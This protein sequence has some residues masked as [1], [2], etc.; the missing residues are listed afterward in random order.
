[1][2]WTAKPLIL[3]SLSPSQALSHYPFPHLF[4]AVS[5]TSHSA[6]Y[7]IC[8]AALLMLI[9]CRVNRHVNKPPRRRR[10]EEES[11]EVTKWS[12]NREGVDDSLG[13]LCLATPTPGSLKHRD[14]QLFH[15]RVNPVN[16]SCFLSNNKC[17]TIIIFPR[18]CSP[19]PLWRSVLQSRNHREMNRLKIKFPHVACRY[20]PRCK[21]ADLL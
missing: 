11:R 18:G 10:A 5:D 16:L 19:L 2:K 14:K 1:M 4:V 3:L 17:Y 15:G 8:Q 7:N 13:R 9:E 6:S 12:K 21:V 20:V